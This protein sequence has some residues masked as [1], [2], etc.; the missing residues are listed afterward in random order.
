MFFRNKKNED[1][2]K[3]LLVLSHK[4]TEDIKKQLFEFQEQWTQEKQEQHQNTE[5][6]TRQQQA[7]L[8]AI[9]KLTAQLSSLDENIKGSEKQIRR[10]S[11]S[12]EDLLEEIQDQRKEK[13]LLENLLKEKAQ[14]EKALLSLVDC[15]RGQMEL[16]CEQ[17]QKTA[18]QDEKTRL[19]W[20]QQL[21]MMNSEIKRLMQQCGMEEVGEPDTLVNYDYCE[22]LEAIDTEDE[23]QVGKIAKVYRQGRLYCGQVIAKAQVAA[24]RRKVNGL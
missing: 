2:L 11:R 12:F 17:L 24:Y 21:Q 18:C 3:E 19:A 22:V 15:C 7:Q 6:I 14:R 13:E 20:E 16:F 5:E 8:E 1:E 9:D 23:N 4:E 10:Q